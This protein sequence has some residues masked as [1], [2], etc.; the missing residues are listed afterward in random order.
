MSARVAKLE[1]LLTR[2]Q[3]RATQPRSLGIF[4]VSTEE[5]A[6]SSEEISSDEIEGRTEELAPIDGLDDID[7]VQEID[8]V[9]LDEKGIPSSGAVAAAEATMDDAIDA[10]AHQPPVTPPPESGEELT[11]PQF[12]VSTGPTMEQLGQTIAL[13]EG[14]SQDFELDEP[15]LDE[16]GLSEPPKSQREEAL[17]ASSPP[18][19][20]DLTLPENAREELDRVR[21]GDSTPLEARVS[22]RPVLSTNVVDLVSSAREFAP[23]SFLEL[24]EASLKLK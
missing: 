2:I 10:A 18:S 20:D 9:E 12:P 1:A 17:P 5:L 6:T 13:E 14:G 21:L 23:K 4:A 16:P 15:T 22:A 19:Q 24:V 7:D 3:E 11:R 8:D